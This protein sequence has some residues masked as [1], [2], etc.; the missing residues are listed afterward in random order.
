MDSFFLI[1]FL[2]TI[3]FALYFVKMDWIC[4]LCLVLFT[5]DS[6]H[7]SGSVVGIVLVILGGQ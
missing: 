3:F 2:G 7:I 4:T 1:H 6:F 5:F